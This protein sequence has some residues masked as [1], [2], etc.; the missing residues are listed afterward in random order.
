MLTLIK[1][2]I[3][4]MF[5]IYLFLAVYA[6]FICI[7]LWYFHNRPS[8]NESLGLDINFDGTLVMFFWTWP[9]YFIIGT[10]GATQMSLD[11]SQKISS[12]LNTLAAT[13]RAMW[14]SRLSAGIIAILII[15]VPMAIT[16]MIL[17]QKI[18]IGIPI[19]LNMLYL[20]FVISFS[21]FFACYGGGL[22]C[23]WRSNS[24]FARL[25]SVVITVA[26]ITIFS[27]KGFS[28]EVVAIYLAFGVVCIIR[29]GYKF[30]NASL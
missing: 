20:L 4:D 2:E 21:L 15:L 19:N 7:S 11:K 5:V 22:M 29:A 10:L 3:R 1:R 18:N 14:L 8:C 28:Y 26:L 16:E 23:G 27:I 25:A 30:L 9:L 24:I 6:V 12:F 13:R 17:Y